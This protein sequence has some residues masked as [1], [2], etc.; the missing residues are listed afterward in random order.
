MTKAMED[1]V[2]LVLDSPI[3]SSQIWDWVPIYGD[4]QFKITFMTNANFSLLIRKFFLLCWFNWSEIFD[5]RSFK[6]LYFPL[7]LYFLLVR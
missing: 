6:F 5:F 7:I 1:T 3:H 4:N 2:N